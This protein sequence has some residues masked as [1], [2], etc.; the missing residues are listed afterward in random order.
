MGIRETDEEVLGGPTYEVRINDDE[1]FYVTINEKGGVPGEVVIRFDVPEYFEWVTILTIFITRMLEV[2]IPLANIAKD[3]KDIH[4]PRTSHFIPGGGGEARS[5][6][7]RIG[8]VFEQ[9]LEG[10]AS[11][12][13]CED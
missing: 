1:S 13:K 9:Y 7:D 5:I 4:S 8:R 3:L 12:D 11:G 10:K 2:G 6:C